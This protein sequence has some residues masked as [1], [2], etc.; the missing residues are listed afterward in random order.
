MLSDTWTQTLGDA[1]VGRSGLPLPSHLWPLSLLNI[2]G[3]KCKDSGLVT[4]AAL[5]W[6]LEWDSQGCFLDAISSHAVGKMGEV[7]SRE[8]LSKRSGRWPNLAHAPS[9][10]TPL[11]FL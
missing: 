7:W 11:P 3:V 10:L 2:L 6:N 1:G 9:P 5:Q 4:S 8:Y